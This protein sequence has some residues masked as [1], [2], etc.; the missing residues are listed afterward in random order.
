MKNENSKKIEKNPNM[1]IRRGFGRHE[2]FSD[3][4]N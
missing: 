2:I 1:R 4:K 3:K